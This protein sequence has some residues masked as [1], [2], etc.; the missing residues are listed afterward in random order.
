MIF[1]NSNFKKVGFPH[2]HGSWGFFLEPI[3]LSLIVAYSINGFLLGLAAFSLFLSSQPLSYILKRIPKY[4]LKSSYVFFFA[5]LSFS[6][7]ILTYLNFSLNSTARLVPFFA[8]ILLMG[9]FKL[10]ELKSL[11]RNLIVELIPQIA[12][13]LMSVSILLVDNWELVPIIGF[14]AIIFSRS[15]QTV[16]YIN[17][18]LK[19]FKGTK[20]NKA[21]VNLIGL[22]FLITII[23]MTQFN[24]V[25]WISVLAIILLMLR[26]AIGFFKKNKLEKVKIIGIKEFIYGFL[27][28]VLISI[29]YNFGL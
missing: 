19:F 28:V 4:L 13:G 22:L 17:N 12:V 21:L 25:P 29:G 9:I 11:N 16:F 27:F 3:V 24:I 6:I 5:Y 8:A 23:I 15:I 14:V 2:E 26:S 20:P 18:K 10:L 7:F 1:E